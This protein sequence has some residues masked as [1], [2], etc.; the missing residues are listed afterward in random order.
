LIANTSSWNDQCQICHFI[1]RLA[2]AHCR[3]P[4]NANLTE[5]R[6]QGLGGVLCWTSGTGGQAM[7]EFIEREA[8]ISYIKEN[9]CK[10]CSDIGLCGKCAVLTAVKLFESIPAADVRPVVRGKWEDVEVTYIAD[11]TTLPFERISTMRCNQ[12]NRY[13]TEIYYYGNPTEMAHFCPNCGA[14]MEEI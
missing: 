7:A 5:K 11:K 4:K 1:G 8:A 6:S 10:S 3:L 9:Q 12:C 2:N 14:R 13:H